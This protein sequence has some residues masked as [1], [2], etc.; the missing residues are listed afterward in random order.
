[1]N[2]YQSTPGQLIPMIAVQKPGDKSAIPRI[3]GRLGHAAV[4]AHFAGRN[5][6]DGSAERLIALASLILDTIS[7]GPTMGT[8]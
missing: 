4:R 6:K 3:S 2:P 8:S 5:R 7:V 1:M